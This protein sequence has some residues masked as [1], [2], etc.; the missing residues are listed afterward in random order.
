MRLLPYIEAEAAHCAATGEPLMRPFFLDWP[1][2]R[3]AWEISDQYCF[4]R[5]LLVAPVVEPGST[6][7]WLYLPAG[8]W[9]DLWDGTRLDGSRWISRP[10]P[11]D[12]IPVYRRVGASWPN[13]SI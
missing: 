1:D 5:A 7:R 6:H 12:V 4:G 8:E 13:L 3:E 9:E 11:I 2:D 10:A